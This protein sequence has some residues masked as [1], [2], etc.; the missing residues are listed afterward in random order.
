MKQLMSLLHRHPNIQKQLLQLIMLDKLHINVI[1]THKHQVNDVI[2]T[3]TQC[4][5]ER[6]RKWLSNQGHTLK[7]D[8]IE[9]HTRQIC[10]TLFNGISLFKDMFIDTDGERGQDFVI[11]NFVIRNIE[12]SQIVISCEYDDEDDDYIEV[13]IDY[14]IIKKL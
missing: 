6:F 3:I 10:H 5:Y 4:L 13:D 12:L 14:D 11:V 7:Y 1:D 2:K 9:N 8:L